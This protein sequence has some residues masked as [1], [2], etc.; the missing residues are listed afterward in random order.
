M[1]IIYLIACLCLVSCH[2]DRRYNSPLEIYEEGIA[3]SDTRTVQHN[4]RQLILENYKDTIVTAPEELHSRSIGEII[5]RAYQ[6]KWQKNYVLKKEFSFGH[7]RRSQDGTTRGSLVAT[8][9]SVWTDRYRGQD[10]A[11]F[12]TSAHVQRHGYAVKIDKDGGLNATSMAYRIDRGRSIRQSYWLFNVP[13]G[14]I[15]EFT[16]MVP[17]AGSRASGWGIAYFGRKDGLLRFK[18]FELNA[19]GDMHGHIVYEHNLETSKEMIVRGVTF[20]IEELK[21]NGIIKFRI[22]GKQKK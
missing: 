7:E 10:G 18:I 14:P 13:E 1:R 12:M 21:D 3:T 17:R 16:G 5:Y 6:G 9:G 20:T 22:A 8:K 2:H 19:R 15:F 11:I 4:S